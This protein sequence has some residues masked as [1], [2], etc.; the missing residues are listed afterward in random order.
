VHLL[1]LALRHMLN[2]KRKKRRHSL[3]NSPIFP[4]ALKL[5]EIHCQATQKYWPVL[6]RW[7]RTHP[8]P[9]NRRARPKPRT[10]KRT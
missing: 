3:R 2:P 5:L 7:K 9:G 4:E 10:P 6:H 8:H 1:H